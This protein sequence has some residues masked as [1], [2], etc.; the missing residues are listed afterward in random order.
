MK[1]LFLGLCLSL[2]L[3]A[4]SGIVIAACDRYVDQ[5]VRSLKFLK[6]EINTSLP[7][8][9]WYAG[10]ELSDENQ[11]RLLA[12]DHL[13][14]H[15]ITT[16]FPLPPE[17]FRGFQIKG[18]L[19]LAT[20]FDEFIIMD[21]DLYFYQ[22]PESLFE[23]P[24]YKKTGAFFFCDQESYLFF[25]FPHVPAQKYHGGTLSYYEKRKSFLTHLIEK[26][27]ESFPQKW[28]FYW[29]SIQPTPLNPIP[30]EHLESGC[31]VI[32][33]KR[34]QKGLEMVRRLNED[35]KETYK[36]VWGDKETFWI[37]FEMAH[38]PY[39]VNE[40]IPAKIIDRWL[41]YLPFQIKKVALVQTVDGK[42]FYQQ[43]APAKL[44]PSAKLVQ[45]N[46][47]KTTRTLSSQEIALLNRAF[48]L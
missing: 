19:G 28:T 29:S 45:R 40:T 5:L 30:S 21:A 39:H 7:I 18:Y 10:D 4:S 33:R 47:E 17:H 24:A 48:E 8:E 11:R 25:G 38:E 15:D 27:S 12:F 42:L 41:P 43:K 37:G 1:K 6:T 34:H 46:G 14:L 9:I 22:K 31:V 36:Y 16:I 32:D 23:H 26:T 20:Q 3:H 13:T 35:Y 2:S 44:S